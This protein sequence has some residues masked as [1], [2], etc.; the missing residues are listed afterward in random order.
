MQTY[1]VDL[2]GLSFY[3]FGVNQQ[4]NTAPAANL[5]T[6]T[7]GPFYETVRTSRASSHRPN[8]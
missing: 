4:D 6:G 5:F 7:A 1:S 3:S 8:S 2:V